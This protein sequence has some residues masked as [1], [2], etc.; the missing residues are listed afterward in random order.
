MSS[1][2][3]EEELNVESEKFNPLKALYSKKLQLPNVQSFDNF[4]TFLSRLKAADN[5]LDADLSN[6]KQTRKQN[7][8]EETEVEVD[9]NKYH[10]TAAGRIFLREQGEIEI[11][12]L[13]LQFWRKIIIFIAPIK[14]RKRAKD[15]RNVLTRIDQNVTG[16]ISLLH[17]FYI[18]QTRV[19]I[20]T[21]KE[22]GIRGYVT[23]IIEAYDKHPNLVLKQCK[24]VWTRR[25]YDF[26]DNNTCFGEPKDCS[27]KLKSLGFVIPEIEV[28]SINRKKVECERYFERMLIRGEDVVLIFKHPDLEWWNK[29]KELYINLTPTF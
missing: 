22:H 14:G 16:P 23:G 6:F 10:K 9:E 25:K 11:C 5:V 18:E 12:K 8:V 29:W 2:T 26:S 27:D 24:E 15:T 28:K 20:Y 13:N 4:G 17:K 3:D 1:S 21:R 19:K 7:I